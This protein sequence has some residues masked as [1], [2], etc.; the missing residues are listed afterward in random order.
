MVRTDLRGREVGRCHDDPGRRD[1]EGPAAQGD[2]RGY[3]TVGDVVEP[4][5]VAGKVIARLPS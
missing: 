1:G 3:R 2:G 4:A 5:F